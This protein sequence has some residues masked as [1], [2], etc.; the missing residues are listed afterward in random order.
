MLEMCVLRINLRSYFKT[1]NVE[2]QIGSYSMNI[3][4]RIS[5]LIIWIDVSFLVTNIILY[6]MSARGLCLVDYIY[7]YAYNNRI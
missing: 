4:N 6:I 5:E 2:D 3:V 1:G 7:I